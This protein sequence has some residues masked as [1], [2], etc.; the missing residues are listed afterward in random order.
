MREVLDKH[1]QVVGLRA[2]GNSARAGWRCGR[3]QS[4]AARMDQSCRSWACRR[5][6]SLPASTTSTHGSSGCPCRT[7][8]RRSRSSST[9][10]GSGRTRPVTLVCRV[11][12]HPAFKLHRLRHC[13]IEARSFSGNTGPRHT[14]ILAGVLIVLIV[15]AAGLLIRPGSG[16]P[17]HQEPARRW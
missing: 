15:I 3:G 7:W 12:A 1:P 4:G 8:K 9:W 11:R 2:R 5:R 14:R 10:P 16:D 6:T 17:A 13:G